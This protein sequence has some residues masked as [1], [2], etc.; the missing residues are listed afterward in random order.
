MVS[1]VTRSIQR[2]RFL[3]DEAALEVW[4]ED[5]PSLVESTENLVDSS[6]F[7]ANH[8]GVDGVL[9]KTIVPLGIEPL[10]LLW[11]GVPFVWLYRLCDGIVERPQD[12]FETLLLIGPRAD[13]V[14][15]PAGNRWLGHS[16]LVCEFILGPL[17][18]GPSPSYGVSNHVVTPGAVL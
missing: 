16:N 18:Q 1:D 11:P 6:R 12:G 13:A 2:S 10:E 15:F 14:A 7:R 3:P 4:V 17:P 8:D 9:P 5:H